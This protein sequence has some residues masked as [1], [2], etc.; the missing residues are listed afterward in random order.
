MTT[1]TTE[2]RQPVLLPEAESIAFA[3]FRTTEGRSNPYPLY[4]RLR[5]LAP[6]HRSE[7]ARAWLLTRYE[8][9]KASLR[10]PRFEKRWDEALDAR[11]SHWRERP[12]LVWAG[13][14]LLNLD[15]PIHTRLRRYVFRWFTR[16]S[17]ERLRPT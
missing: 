17:V 2:T 8:D 9:C 7:T 11:S 5:E 3:L 15:A 6:V 10:D 16:G 14:T 4:H 13:K 12:A 1:Q